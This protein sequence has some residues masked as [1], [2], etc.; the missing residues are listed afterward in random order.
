MNHQDRIHPRPPCNQT[1]AEDTPG[2]YNLDWK[3]IV[4][5]HLGDI[6]NHMDLD[7]NQHQVQSVRD[8]LDNLSQDEESLLDE[9]LDQLADRH[10][11]ALLQALLPLSVE[12]FQELI[13]MAEA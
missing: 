10:Q 13:K 4:A 2:H 8:Y 11:E 12:A 9:K 6:I 1:R 3:P 7:L 5:W